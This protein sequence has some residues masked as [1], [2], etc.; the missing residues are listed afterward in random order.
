[1]KFWRVCNWIPGAKPGENG[2]PLYVWPRQGAGRVD[3]PDSEYR[4]LYVGDSA[5]GAASEAFGQYAKW[6]PAVLEPPPS[7]AGEAVKALVQYEGDAEILDLDDPYALQDIGLRPSGV[8]TRNRGSTQQWA[9]GIY[10]RGAHQG[11]SWWSYYGPQWA[12][13]GLW[14]VS[15]LLVVGVPEELTLRH[16]VMES[17]AGAIR[18]IIVDK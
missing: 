1:M 16:P 10:D 12:S 4:V 11:V 9:R 7:M 17:A 2:H 8:V 18:R 15:A 5:E 6:T 3:D 13:V 14:D